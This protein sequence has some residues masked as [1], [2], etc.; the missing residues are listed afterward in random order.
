MTVR[1]I[2][3]PSSRKLF[4]GL[5]LTFALEIFSYRA[6]A[7]ALRPHHDAAGA[8]IYSGAS[9]ADGGAVSYYHDL[10]YVAAAVQ[11]L[12][13]LWDGAWWLLL[14]V[15]GYGFYKLFELV[16]WP[17]WSAPTQQ[18]PVEGP[19]ERRRREKKER[20]AARLQKFAR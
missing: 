15:P 19:D 17:R 14:A 11:L 3:F 1:L 6:I 10:L 12:G 20:Q 5:A 4:A 16:L 18:E 7:A 8:L 9:L 2:L 13:S